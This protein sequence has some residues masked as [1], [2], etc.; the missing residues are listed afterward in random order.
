MSATKG[1]HPV[2]A[3]HTP[4]QR[5]DLWLILRVWVSWRIMSTQDLQTTNPWLAYGWLNWDDHR[6]RS[7]PLAPISSYFI[8]CVIM[9][10]HISSYGEWTKPSI[11]LD[12]WIP[13]NNGIKQYKTSINRCRISSTVVH[14]AIEF[15]Q[16]WGWHEKPHVCFEVVPTCQPWIS[17]TRAAFQVGSGWPPHSIEIE[18]KHTSNKS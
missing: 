15:Y 9:F 14:R 5:Q 4:V 3:N 8:V 2:F 11:T 10:H 16:A 7:W 13:I 18:L 12:G 17:T 6:S 1:P